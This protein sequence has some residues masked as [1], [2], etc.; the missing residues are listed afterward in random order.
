MVRSASYRV[1]RCV[2]GL[3][4]SFGTLLK[5]GSAAAAPALIPIIDLPGATFTHGRS[6]SADGSTVVGFY[7]TASTSGAFYWTA[8]TGMVS[9]GTNPSATAWA[10]SGDGSVI[11]GQ[12]LPAPTDAFRWTSAGG[13]T[14]LSA[15]LG[16][17][18]AREVSADGTVVVGRIGGSNAFRWTQAT[19]AVLFGSGDAFDVSNDGNV[20]AGRYNS[21]NGQE[22]FRWTQGSGIVGLGDLPLGAFNSQATGISADGTVIVGSGT[23]ASGREA[24]RYTASGGMVPLG[25]LPGGGFLSEANAVSDD[26]NVVVGLGTGGDGNGAFYW[27]P[28]GGMQS[29]WDVL[30]AAGVNPALDGWTSFSVANH[31]SADGT[32]I[33][34]GG[35]RNGMSTAFLAI[36]PEPGSLSLLAITG[37]SLLRRRRR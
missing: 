15:G 13:A 20:I 7:Q 22:A 4:F 6:V 37:I 25:D 5:A 32:R 12:G 23:S 35:T 16:V 30:L 3:A 17:G 31:V 27:T 26:G 36:V 33:I 21:P 19:G 11:V 14:N 28:T 10:T 29:L 2:A 9:I 18:L 34:G 1:G 24:I 8:P